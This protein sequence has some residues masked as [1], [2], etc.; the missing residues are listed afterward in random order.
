MISNVGVLKFLEMQQTDVFY[1]LSDTQT[2]MYGVC[3]HHYMYDI[4]VVPG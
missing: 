2:P 1:S 3:R 4:H